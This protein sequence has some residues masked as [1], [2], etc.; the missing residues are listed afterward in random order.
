MLIIRLQRVGRVHEPT[1]RI[2]LTDSKFGP[3][4][5]KSVEVLGSYDARKGKG[6]NHVDGEKVKYW[7]SKGAKVSET[8]NNFLIDEKVLTGKKINVLPK[9]KIINAK[10]AK[11]AEEAAKAAK[12]APAPVVETPVA[13]VET[14]TPEPLAETPAV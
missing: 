12:L 8:V 14:T 9:N 7:I 4:S 13:P 2:V 6:N 11:E 1:F 3:K 10:K 5:G